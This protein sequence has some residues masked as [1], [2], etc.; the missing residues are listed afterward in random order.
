MGVIYTTTKQGAKTR[1]LTP[2]EY[3]QLVQVINTD[4]L[5]TLLR[6]CFYTG[7]RYAEIQQLYQ[8]PEYWK[9]DQQMICLDRTDQ[10]NVKR[11]TPE[12]WIPVPS[13][14]QGELPYFFETKK[15]PVLKVWGEDLKR[16]AEKAGIS[17]IGIVPKVTRATIEVWMY[18]AEV[19]LN[20]ICLR[21]GHDKLSALNNYQETSQMFSLAEIQEIKKR[22]TG[23]QAT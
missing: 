19:P 22:L 1:I 13:Q 9:H 12:R 23:W 2:S 6:V 11:I 21:Q 14:L 5:R 18:V 17:T 7:L 16:W 10:K 20:Q 4:R 3:D 15:P 8:H